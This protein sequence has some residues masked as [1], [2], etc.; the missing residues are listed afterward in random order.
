MPPKGTKSPRAKSPKS[1][2]PGGGSTWE[3]LL[4]TM[5]INQ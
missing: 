1:A 5:S 3:T 2:K 4:G